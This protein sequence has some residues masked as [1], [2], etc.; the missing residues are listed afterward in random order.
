MV[1]T[2]LESILLI[3][4]FWKLKCQPSAFQ[5]PR[6]GNLK[7]TFPKQ[8]SPLAD[9]QLKCKSFPL[10]EWKNNK[11]IHTSWRKHK[12]T[13]WRVRQMH[14]SLKNFTMAHKRIS[15]GTHTHTHTH[16]HRRRRQKLALH[17][18]QLDNFEF[19]IVPLVDTRI[20][21]SSAIEIQKNSQELV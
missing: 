15:W 10:R 14:K 12:R 19:L 6:I 20:C 2:N 8:T 17:R 4:L 9:Y 16:T 7:R 13:N 3:Q 21:A 11:F 5:V 1:L 18:G